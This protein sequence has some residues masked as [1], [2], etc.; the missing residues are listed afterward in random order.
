MTRLPIT[1]TTS[2]LRKHIY[3]VMIQDKVRTSTYASFILTNPIIFRDAVV[4]D[5]GCG[6]GILCLLAAESGA[7]HVY[8]VDASDIAEK[9]GQIVRADGLENVIT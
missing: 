9:A 8:A 1:L 3:A 4:L 2:S 5:V 6:T 7:M